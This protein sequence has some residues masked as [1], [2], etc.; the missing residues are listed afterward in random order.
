MSHTTAAAALTVGQAPYNVLFILTDQERYFRPGELPRDYR[1]PGHERLTARRCREGLT[2]AGWRLTRSRT[3]EF[4]PC[5]KCGRRV[6]GGTNV[7]VA[8]L[9]NPPSAVCSL[10]LGAWASTAA[11]RQ[12]ALACPAR[13]ERATSRL[14]GGCSIQLSYGQLL[15]QRARF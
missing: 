11:L 13:I 6:I 1:L 10:C 8:G 7:V 3:S 14:E 2:A 12:P 4:G 9:L 5:R 15:W